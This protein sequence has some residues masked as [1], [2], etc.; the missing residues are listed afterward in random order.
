MDLCNLRD[1]ILK[2]FEMASIMDALSAIYTVFSP[3]C[4][5]RVAHS[6]AAGTAGLFHHCGG[7]L[8]WLKRPNFVTLVI[9][10]KSNDFACEDSKALTC[11]VIL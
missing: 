8:D 2:G 3:G 6:P 10:P 7:S 1:I 11:F 9:S 4:K 5:S